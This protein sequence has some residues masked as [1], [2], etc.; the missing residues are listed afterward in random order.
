MLL[1]TVLRKCLFLSDVLSAVAEIRTSV[2]V[3]TWTEIAR[4][5]GAK[6]EPGL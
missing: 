2:R 1:I 4:T 5:I 6:Q 3:R